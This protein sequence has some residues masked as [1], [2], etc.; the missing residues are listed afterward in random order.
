MERLEDNGENTRE[1]VLRSTVNTG[2]GIAAV[3]ASPGGALSSRHPVR[4]FALPPLAFLSSIPL[5]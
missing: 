3:V 1:D 4:S 5:K 2:G